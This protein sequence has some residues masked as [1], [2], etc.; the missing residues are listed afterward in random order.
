MLI[1]RWIRTPRLLRWEEYSAM[2][3]GIG[4]C[5][6]TVANFW[7]I[8]LGLE[9]GWSRNLRTIMGDKD[10]RNPGSSSLCQKMQQL[11]KRQWQIRFVH[12]YTEANSVADSIAKSC[13]PLSFF[14]FPSL[15]PSSVLS[16]NSSLN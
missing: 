4:A 10:M 6:V 11:C 3:R 13:P 7:A 12:V 14:F 16:M 9:V 15:N 1:E 2:T 5:S 8:L